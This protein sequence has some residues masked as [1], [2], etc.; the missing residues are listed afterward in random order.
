MEDLQKEIQEAIEKSVKDGF[1]LREILDKPIYE[2]VGTYEGIT[3]TKYI[4]S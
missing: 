2:F 4:G 1:T 3:L